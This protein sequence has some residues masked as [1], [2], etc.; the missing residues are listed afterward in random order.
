ME[1]CKNCG[2]ER[3]N[4]YVEIPNPRKKMLKNVVLWCYPLSKSITPR[5]KRYMMK[6]AYEVKNEKEL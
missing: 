6:F 3:A 1:K 4:H 5:D 2:K